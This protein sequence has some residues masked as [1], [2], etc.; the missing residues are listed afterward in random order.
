MTDVTEQLRRLVSPE[1]K[2]KIVQEIVH[3]CGDIHAEKPTEEDAKFLV[4][5][6]L[7]IGE[8]TK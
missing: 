4:R 1:T 5:Q 7:L 2:L 3:T 8:V 6:M